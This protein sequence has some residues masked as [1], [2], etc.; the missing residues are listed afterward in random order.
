VARRQQGEDPDG[1]EYFALSTPSNEFVLVSWCARAKALAP[2]RED[3]SLTESEI[4]ILS[5]VLLGDSNEA[6]ARARKRSVRTVANQIASIFHKFRVRSRREL[7]AH[8]LA[9]SHEHLA[10]RMEI[11]PQP[12]APA[13]LHTDEP[14]LRYLKPQASAS[15]GEDR[16]QSSTPTRPVHKR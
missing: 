10:P 8:F 12:A 7:M 6:I 14:D 3:M 1:P 5:Q 4:S 2:I 16:P 15:P 13:E 9:A 11:P